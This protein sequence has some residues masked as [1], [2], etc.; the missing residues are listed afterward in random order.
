MAGVVQRKMINK[1]AQKLGKLGGL[2]TKKKHGK[3]HYQMLAENMNKKIKE[4]KKNEK[5]KRNI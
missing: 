4:K 5:N 2:A 1:N 3:K